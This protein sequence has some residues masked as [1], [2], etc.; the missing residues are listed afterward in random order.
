MPGE[1]ELGSTSCY[2]ITAAAAA[3]L[4]VGLS[5]SGRPTRRLLNLTRR[6]KRRRADNTS[7]RKHPRAGDVDIMPAGDVNGDVVTVLTATITANQQQQ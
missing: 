5:D 1:D 3:R 4:A 7:G 6:N 2:H